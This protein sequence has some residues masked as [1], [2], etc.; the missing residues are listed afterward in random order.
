MHDRSENL[1]K[2]TIIISN[3]VSRHLA[4]RTEEGNKRIRPVIHSPG[5]DI[6]Q[7]Y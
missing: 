3:A 6:V 5:R 4:V 7:A 1:W 2:E